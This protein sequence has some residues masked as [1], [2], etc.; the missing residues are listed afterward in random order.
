MLAP[1][2]SPAPRRARRGDAALS[3]FVWG[4]A[5]LPPALFL[6]VAFAFLV[7]A[8]L[9]FGATLIT[10]TFGAALLPIPQ[11]LPAIVP[12]NLAISLVLLYRG[13]RAVEHRVLVRRVLPF[14]GVGVPAG[15]ALFLW[16][17]ASW[18]A[19]I[20]GVFVALMSARELLARRGDVPREVPRAIERLLL[21]TGGIM[22]GA[23]SSGGPFVVYV[24][25]RLG[26]SKEG[27]RA[28]LSVLWLVMSVVLLL[29][30]AVGGHMS[31]TTLE[32]SGWLALAGGVGM[33]IGQIVFD[34]MPQESFRGFVFGLLALAGIALAVR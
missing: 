25:G 18:L 11:L 12:I 29:T 16:V 22:H 17:D 4:Q 24:L 23:F 21:V 32:R 20:L 13:R 3:P 34:R 15:L 2:R 9:G 33:V 19:R 27:F 10:V 30:Y 28:T 14:M 7:E 31:A 5:D 1:D 8:S 6:V 26:L